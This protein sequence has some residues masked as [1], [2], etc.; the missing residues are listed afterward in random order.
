VAA[1]ERK[2]NGERNGVEDDKCVLGQM[3]HKRTGK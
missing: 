2:S 3:H 1:R